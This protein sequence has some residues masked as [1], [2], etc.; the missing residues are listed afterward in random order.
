MLENKPYAQHVSKR[1]LDFCAAATPWSRRLWRLG[2]L[3]EIDELIEAAQARHESAL[4]EGS[5]KYF[6]QSL[7]TRV[8]RDLGLGSESRRGQIIT[9]VNRAF[10]PKSHDSEALTLLNSESR[11]AYLANWAGAVADEDVPSEVV[12]RAAT[13]HLLDQGYSSQFIH[14]WLTYHIKYRADHLSLSDL[15]D[16]AH[17]LSLRPKVNYQV[18]VPVDAMPALPVERESCWLSPT[19]TAQWLD[20]WFPLAQHPRQSGGLLLDI[21]S[22][23][24]YSLQADV[25]TWLERLSSRFRVG[26]RERLEFHSQFFMLG[27]SEPVSYLPGPRR[28][29]VLSLEKTAE[30]FRLRLAPQIDAALEILEPLDRGPAVPALAGSWAAIESLL[31]G[32]GDAENRVVAATRMAQIVGCSYVG[33]EL[34]ALSDAYASSMTDDLARQLRVIRD[35]RLRASAFEKALRNDTTLTMPALRHMAALERM[36]EL[37]AD[38]AKILPRIV[39]QLEDAFRRLYRQRNLIVHAGR[40]SSVAMAGTLR[41]VA[42]LVGAGIDRIVHA[43]VTEHKDPLMF[44]ATTAV[45]LAQ[46]QQGAADSFAEIL[47]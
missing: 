40:T 8:R 23:D 32:P 12:A 15:F 10:V 31:V 20:E 3:L 22:R 43:S 27:D 42:P 41:T 44:T 37:I 9:Y 2:A 36:K 11:Q 16:E 28:V 26:T 17:S 21:Q 35:G 30:I 33:L 19:E 18:L 38:P 24:V 46:A 45:R 29:Q 5:L 6:R 4:S 25:K 7:A 39:Q 1:M 14:K 13:S 34:L 47:G